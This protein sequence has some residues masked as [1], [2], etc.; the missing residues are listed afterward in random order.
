M[1]PNIG[2]GANMA[3]E[4]AAA[5][6]NLLGHLK[7]SSSSPPTDSQIE[8]L[9]DQYRT[10]RYQ[11]VKSIYRSSRFLVRFQ[12]RDGLFNTLLS[13]YYAPYAGDLPAD[14]ASKTIAD[15]VMCDFLPHPK[16]SGDG[17]KRY[18]RNGQ[19]WGWWAQAMMYILILII[20]YKWAGRDYLGSMIICAPLDYLR[21]I[22][23]K[24]IRGK[25]ILAF[26]EWIQLP[27]DKLA[28]VQEVINLLH[29]ASLLI[30]DI[31]DASR[32]RR[33]HPVAHEVFGVAQ[34]INAANYAYFLQQ[35]RLNEINDPRAFHIFTHALLD[36]HRG[37]GMDLYW[38]DAVVCP[39]EEE[40]IQ[41]VIYKTGGLFR[42]AV[43]LME[44]QSTRTVDL[45][46]LVE[47]LGVIFQIRDDYMNL[48][49]GL[50]AEKKG[51]MEDLTEGKF[52]YLVIHSVHAAPE[53]TFLVDILKQRS[54]DDALKIRAVQY[55]ESTGSFQYCRETLGRLAQ[56]ARTHVEELEASLGP[57]KGI[58]RILDLL[59]VQQPDEKPT[60]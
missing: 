47:L 25:L 32:L 29:T 36:L 35:E 55:M 44:I 24:N 21:S 28:I 7:I 11:R 23:G 43:E 3:I 17:W 20:L 46:K 39:T 5:L 13:R 31:Q 52:S 1:T 16:R 33:G 9:L 42:L 58:H 8:K 22:P 4:D 6:S 49:S 56:Q 60:V 37:Q 53:N 30:D 54:E 18:R 27:N 38:R 14:M 34:T 40:Y 59:H 15:G 2:Q 41:M 57:N 50:Y 12:A 45:S 51:R 26:N 19:S 48:Q 10:I